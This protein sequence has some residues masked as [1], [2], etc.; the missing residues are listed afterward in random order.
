MPCYTKTMNIHYS[1]EAA[2]REQTPLDNLFIAEYLSD[3]SGEALKAYLYGLMLCH[4]PSMEV[5]DMGFALGLTES[6]LLTA[7]VYWQSK[8]L[9]RIAGEDPLEVEYLTVE[10]PASTVATPMKYASFLRAL[11]ALMAPR[12]FNA[13][14][15]KHI[16]DL[17][18]IFRLE[19]GA[20]LE[21]MGYCME[22]KGRNVSVQYVLTVGK[23]WA[24]KGITTQQQAKIHITDTAARKHGAGEILRRWNKRRMPTVDEMEL[25][26]TWIQDW[27]FDQEAIL[28]VCPRLTGVSTPSFALL[29]EQL[30]ALYTEGKTK[31]SDIRSEQ[32]T[33]SLEK[34]FAKKVFAAMGKVELPSASQIRQLSAFTKGEKALPEEVVLLA[35]ESCLQAERPFGKLKTVLSD[36]V[37]KG[38]ENTEQAQQALS[39]FT[40][41]YKKTRKTPYATEYAQHDN[42]K[43]SIADIS[44]DLD[45]ELPLIP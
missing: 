43:V 34:E 32:E 24:D 8:G 36:W 11:N 23:S 26:D 37:L 35:A 19:E 20:V 14:E 28:A 40:A 2:R 33:E 17:I 9:V 45:S 31:L 4:Y 13:R 21:L 30:E 15:L 38:I 7:F 29:G 12:S 1:P 10:Q 42:S 44:L 18:E 5:E 27:G 39:A 41:S 25:Y 6:Q 22:N 16:Y 3:C